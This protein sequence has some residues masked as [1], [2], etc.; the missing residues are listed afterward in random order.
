[1]DPED[2]DRLVAS[3]GL[4][5]SG[6]ESLVRYRGEPYRIVELGADAVS[7]AHLFEDALT[8]GRTLPYERLRA[9]YEAG[10]F[11]AAAVAPAEDRS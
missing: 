1:M 2:T 7:L 6:P 9:A 3:L 10:A 4:D 5:D 8:A 11:T